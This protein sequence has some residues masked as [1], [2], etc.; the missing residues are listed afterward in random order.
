MFGY[1]PDVGQHR[2]YVRIAVPPWNNVIV[3]VFFNTCSCGH[4]QV[5]TDIEALRTHGLPEHPETST[6]FLDKKAILFRFKVTDVADMSIGTDK[7]VPVSIGKLVHD[8][9]R[10]ASSVNDEVFHVLVISW[11]G[12]EDA[13]RLL[14]F[15]YDVVDSPRRPDSIHFPL[16]F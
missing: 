14:L 10:A 15:S 11:F 2:H 9:E 5:D 3:Q 6:D 8:G 1:N 13:S 4:T 12:A 7:E 16:F